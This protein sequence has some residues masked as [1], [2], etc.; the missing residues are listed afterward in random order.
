MLSRD[1]SRTTIWSSRVLTLLHVTFVLGKQC[2][3]Q[4]EK[5][6]FADGFLYV[7]NGQ[8]GTETCINIQEMRLAEGKELEV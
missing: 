8:Y 2:D 5:V 7:L 1:I 4:W 6:H 3:F